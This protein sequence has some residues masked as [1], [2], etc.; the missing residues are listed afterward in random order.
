M[1]QPIYDFLILLRDN[2]L[3]PLR[4]ALANS[5]ILNYFLNF[6]NALL[7]G[8]FN[9]SDFGLTLGTSAIASLITII[10]AFYC[11]RFIINLFKNCFNFIINIFDD[12]FAFSGRRRRKRKW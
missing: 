12:Q 10:I 7:N 4:Q 2:F 3:D 11:F 1:Y 6:F 5:G 8:I 9:S